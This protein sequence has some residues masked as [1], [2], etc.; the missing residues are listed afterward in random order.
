MDK[1]DE[2]REAI[3]QSAPLLDRLDE[4][5]ARIGKMCSQR[6]PPKMS[7]PVHWSDDDMFICDTI[8]DAIDVLTKTEPAEAGN[9]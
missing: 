2:I 8:Q 3:R 1:R 9:P 6:R 7:I 5:R 4:C